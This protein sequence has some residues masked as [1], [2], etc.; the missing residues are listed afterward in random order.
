[1]FVLLCERMKKESL[2]SSFQYPS[3]VRPPTMRVEFA[4]LVLENKADELEAFL[5]DNPNFDV[6][7]SVWRADLTT[8]TIYMDHPLHVASRH[9]WRD[10]VG[11]LLKRPTSIITLLSDSEHGRDVKSILP[12]VKD[13]RLD[14]ST[15][16]AEWVTHLAQVLIERNILIY[17]KWLVAL[18]GV[19]ARPQL[20]P[21]LP[22]NP[23]GTFFYTFMEDPMRVAYSTRLQLGFL[24]ESAAYVYVISVLLC[25][26]YVRLRPQQ[27]RLKRV[28]PLIGYHIP[29]PSLPSVTVV[30]FFRM[31]A[32]L[33][34]EL[35]MI[36]ANRCVG[37]TKDHVLH[38][39]S[40][41][42]LQHLGQHLCDVANKQ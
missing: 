34:L 2:N 15:W 41:K 25:D 19:D 39:D 37:S 8:G 6:T 42:A 4:R 16:A 5:A 22:T 26:G 31:M 24:D 21:A 9:G 13:S 20:L 38:A 11:V 1:M 35:Q 40:E 3:R 32:K 17:A 33:P 28:G 36:V 18:Q 12:L 30:G 27:K 14:L 23:V 10:T 7:S 29:D